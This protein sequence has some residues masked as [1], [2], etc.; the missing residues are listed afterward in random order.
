MLGDGSPSAPVVAEAGLTIATGDL[1][2]VSQ[3]WF[4]C[5]RCGFFGAPEFE[6]T[7][8][9]T[10]LVKASVRVLG[11][12][13]AAQAASVPWIDI[14]D[15]TMKL[16]DPERV[17]GGLTRGGLYTTRM[18]LVL[19]TTAKARLVAGVNRVQFRFNGT[20]GESNGYRIVEL[21]L[22]DAQG[23]SLA[24][25]TVQRADIGAEKA[26]GKTLT[27]DVTAG[28][29]LWHGLG[30]LKKS[31]IVNRNL[32]AACASCHAVDGRDLQY[33]NYSNNSIVQRARFHGLSDAQG[34]Q[35]AAYIRYSQRDLPHVAQATPWNPPY[36]PGPGLDA[37]PTV[38][39][40]AGAG[41]NA[42]LDNATQ[43]TKA[44][45]GKP[46]DQ[47][48][49]L[50][51]AD[52][53]S[54]MDV[55]K[56]MNVREIQIPLQFPDW[57]AWLP[58]IHPMDVWPE[59]NAA[60]AG[61]SFLKG[62][63]FANGKQDTLAIHTRAR[64]W[65]QSHLNPNGK[66]GDWS[67]LTD[68]QRDEI[69]NIFLGMG[70]SPNSFLGNADDPNQATG[71]IV[72][73]RYLKS[74][75]NTTTMARADAGAFTVPAFTE[76]AKISLTNWGALQQWE[77]AHTFGLEGNQKWFI[78][79]ADK[80]KNG[81]WVGAG[82]VRGWPFNTFGVFE[83]APHF[84][85][86]NERLPNGVDRNRVMAWEANNIVASLYHT[87]QWY[88]LQMTLNSGAQQAW[89]NF[90][91]DW[92]YIVTWD[93][94]LTDEIGL[95]N[96]AQHE[97][98]KANLVRTLQARI[99]LAQYVNNGY[100]ISKPDPA[101]PN[102]PERD[103]GNNGRAKA[104]FHVT[105]TL[106]VDGGEAYNST[107]PQSRYRLYD[108]LQPGLYKMALNGSIQMFN[109][110]YATQPVSAWRRCDPNA[111]IAGEPEE[112]TGFRFCL[113]RAINPLPSDGKGS[114]QL[115]FGARTDQIVRYGL[116]KTK[117]LGT[118]IEPARLKT[119][120]DWVGAAWPQ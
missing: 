29:A 35:I 6:A 19:D 85:H 86:V 53:D 2:K 64:T 33:F 24:T 57:N 8:Q 56:T 34:K 113:D 4:V 16:A 49:A 103:Q 46:L 114:V 36:Q 76:R 87:N 1:A 82:E 48:L 116:I 79:A 37:K 20:D 93:A 99:K 38:E 23:R 39:W 18:S 119:W 67:H 62:G 88:Q 28:D 95:K 50:T 118:G 25:D 55:T 73:G 27:A 45:F 14:T 44:L 120:S 98:L 10:T 63:T 112:T 74:K 22:Q 26:A 78:R 110:L 61:G 100:P 92:P 106:Y 59:E 111:L 60:A 11:G 89:S 52:I 84:M 91:M 69:Q 83:L 66:Y 58:T 75:A 81:A 12:A 104:L 71:A 17:Q 51:Q 21:Q 15:A 105:P 54:V 96:G 65:L 117:E 77:L 115:P 97:A 41:I 72:G 32:K 107:S 70:F 42:V 68:A 30:L 80:Q 109:Q 94:M 101:A 31:S 90:P 43:A 13:S 3:L 102:I 108:T 5:H 40:A 47:P 9:P 7:T